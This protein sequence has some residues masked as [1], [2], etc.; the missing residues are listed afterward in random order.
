MPLRCVNSHE[1]IPWGLDAAG[2][3]WFA[4]R[5]CVELLAQSSNDSI[6]VEVR[7]AG[8]ELA[9]ACPQW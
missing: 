1:N 9:L 3:V 8:K 7:M 6:M 2:R 4:I 5:V